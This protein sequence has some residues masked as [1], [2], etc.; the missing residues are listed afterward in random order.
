VGANVSDVSDEWPKIGADG[1]RECVVCALRYR[2]L[3]RDA[4]VVAHFDYARRRWCPGGKIP[5][6]A[7][8]A[9]RKR[10]VSVRT[11]SGGLPTLGRG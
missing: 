11:V 6:K 2:A 3:K 7:Q 8:K 5:T 1:K 9:N 4:P 10:K